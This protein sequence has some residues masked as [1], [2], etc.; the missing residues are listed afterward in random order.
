MAKRITEKNVVSPDWVVSWGRP[1]S[2]VFVWEGFVAGL[3]ISIL[4]KNAE[5]RGSLNVPRGNSAG[6]AS[7]G[8]PCAGMAFWNRLNNV[9]M[10]M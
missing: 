4:E 7:A 2:N 9:T 10:G 8:L 6:A 1:V 5:T 3:E